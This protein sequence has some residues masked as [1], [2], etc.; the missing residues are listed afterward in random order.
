MTEG[1]ALPDD[2]FS[3]ARFSVARLVATGGMGQVYEG[4]D[5]ATGE[6]VAIKVL[7]EDAAIHLPRFER[8]VGILR[9]LRHPGIV[10]YVAHGLASLPLLALAERPEVPAPLLPGAHVVLVLEWLEGESL[11]HRLRQG[12]VAVTEG[13]DLVRRVAEAVGHVHR[14]GMV[15]RDLKPSNLILVGGD[16]RAVKVVD[17]GVARRAVPVGE[18]LTRAGVVLGT[19]GY[20][21]PEQA[22]GDGIIDARADVFALGCLLFTCLTGR[23]PFAGADEIAVL[24]RMMLEPAPRL[25]ELRP[26]LPVAL[27]ELLVRWL[28]RRPD[29]RPADGAAA[30]K[31]LEALGRVEG[32][33]AAPLP[34]ATSALTGTERRVMSVV[35][36]HLDLGSAEELATIEMPGSG[37]AVPS[38]ADDPPLETALRA[39]GRRFDAT[40]VI[41][42][43][44]VVALS[45][46]AGSAATDLA[47]RAARCA[48]ALREI[49]PHAPLAVATGWAE[50]THH[51]EANEVIDRATEALRRA[52]T[53]P[54]RLSEPPRSRP[55]GS[56]VGVA[57]PSSPPPMDP[58][59]AAS[60]ER[61]RALRDRPIA[62]D[63]MTKGLLGQRFEVRETEEGPELVAERERAPAARTLLGR[64]T[65]CV[66]RERELSVLRATLDQCV[67]D[68]CARVALVTAAAGVG[69][70]R[71]R[72]E[73]V[74]GVKAGG[75]GPVAVWVGRGD[76]LA[77]GA[78]FALLASAV[79]GALDV[80]SGEAPRAQRAALEVKLGELGV[81]DA[82]IQA[83]FV[84]QMIGL[85]P[86]D[87]PSAAFRAATADQGTMSDRIR[88]AFIAVLAGACD[89]SPVLLVLEDLHWGDVPTVRLVDAALG[90]LAERPLMVL[91]LARPEVHDAFPGLLAA[92]DT[93]EI[94]LPPLP[95]RAAERLVREVLGDAGLAE[96]GSTVLERAQGNAFYLEELIRSVAEGRGD[97]LPETVLAMAHARLDELD[98]DA[99]RLLRAASVFG[100]TFWRDGVLALLG[101]A[102]GA[103]GFDAY[104][105]HLVEREAI[106]R[107]G[108]ARFAGQEELVFRHA[109]LH[110]AAYAALTAEDRRLGHELAVEWL[111]ATGEE[112]AL[113]LAEH[114]QRAGQAERA[115]RWFHRA[116]VQALEGYDYEGALQRAARGLACE[117]DRELEGE[118]LLSEAQAH[119]WLADHERAERAALEAFSRLPPDGPSW[120]AAAT[121]IVGASGRLG[122]PE[123]LLLA[124][125]SLVESFERGVRHVPLLLGLAAAGVQLLYAGHRPE[126]ERALAALEVLAPIFGDLGVG[127][128]ARVRGYHALH[129]GERATYLTESRLAVAALERA[130]DARSATTLGAS[131]G[132][133][134]LALG[135][136]LHAE[137]ELRGAMERAERLGL[138]TARTVAKHNLGLAVAFQ[139]RLDEGRILLAEAL[140]EC[141]AQ[142][143]RRIE[144]GARAYLARVELLR[145]DALAAERE[146]RAALVVA[147]P[148]MR[149]YSLAV[150]A[151]A[152]A[153]QGRV[154]EALAEAREGHRLVAAGTHGEEG[155]GLV[156]VALAACLDA[157]GD[158]EAAAAARAE[159]R[160]RLLERAGKIDDEALRAAF[161]TEIPEHRALVE[162]SA[163]GDPP[164]GSRAPA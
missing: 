34:G 76:P 21:A 138:G 104:L 106:S 153:A 87:E 20:M 140:A 91:C 97:R 126:A 121:E 130:G 52:L 144:V 23:R 36:A 157:A 111:E 102:A 73:F 151:S 79:R 163:A 58:A 96:H 101:G 100:P 72:H 123:P 60:L 152:L 9:Q 135:R 4:L 143:D 28:S 67:L 42:S 146:A 68:S 150:L 44:G 115:A 122:H 105:E 93:F 38:D 131:V 162:G 156:G 26:E 113:V 82:R 64:T 8:E 164:G 94:K 62:I 46:S 53:P 145:G 59:R 134:E 88:A 27:E 142:K 31:E 147:T 114:H 109:L 45:L 3:P 148:S 50:G 118:L 10:R 33:A 159:A 55:P 161:L 90:A 37:A 127:W 69:K 103:P 120:C 85:P 24:V 13:I 43:G 54:P 124:A 154:A 128:R 77:R 63:R 136:L 35:L 15:H 129:R 160:A 17:F 49:A 29:R 110:E 65:P 99:R 22:R 11:A 92:R 139:G 19:P 14:H 2:A 84:A 70:S 107:R 30:A 71:L 75:A 116:A 32:D 155:E 1:P 83:E 158:S 133:A 51:T 95:R 125:R 78:A 117:P 149:A 25:R 39:L 86:S 137:R 56:G 74:S 112:Q 16:P 47:V 81:A 132:F 66:G 119:K 41:L 7:R 80:P 141:L 61:Q 6:R 98:A 40:L 89:R 57:A 108:P 5:H 12:G 18:E 48:V